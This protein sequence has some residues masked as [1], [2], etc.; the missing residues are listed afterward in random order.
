[1]AIEPEL[2]TSQDE[3]IYAAYLPPRGKSFMPSMYAHGSVGLRVSE[4]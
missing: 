4:T 3:N 1:M 2:V